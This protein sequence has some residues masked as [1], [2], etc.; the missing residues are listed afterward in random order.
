MRRTTTTL[1]ALT[2]SLLTT[3]GLGLAALAGEPEQPPAP[4]RPTAQHAW[5][6]RLVGEWDAVCE[7]TM[8]P[9]QPPVQSAARESVRSIGGFWAHVEFTGEAMGA[10]FTGILTLGYD[11]EQQRYVGTWIDSMG[12]Q[13]WQYRGTLDAEGK[14]LTLLTE[15]RCDAAGEVCEFREVIEVLS[16]DEKTFT[17]QRKVNGEF[18]TFMRVRYTRR[19]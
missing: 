7:I 16:A 12:S 3:G 18:V 1:I 5:L 4:P 17:S 9:G 8:E 13:L 11:P 6:E 15:G 10:P 2:C 19:K 14:R